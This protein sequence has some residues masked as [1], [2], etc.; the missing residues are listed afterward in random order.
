MTLDE[1]WLV[2]CGLAQAHPSFAELREALQSIHSIA[3]SRVLNQALPPWP[4][5]VAA[6]ML[7]DL[8][9]PED[10]IDEGD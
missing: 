9:E 6:L 5:P 1:L 3:E 4:F 2:C 7:G 10:V 8:V